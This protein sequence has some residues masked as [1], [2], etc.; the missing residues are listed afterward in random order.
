MFLFDLAEFSVTSAKENLFAA[1]SD[2][3][4]KITSGIGSLAW[5]ATQK[6]GDFMAGVPDFI[7]NSQDPSQPNADYW[8][9]TI[10]TAASEG[11]KIA[12]N[13]NHQ[14]T[15]FLT[16]KAVSESTEG[17]CSNS[18]TAAE[19][20][21]P[22]GFVWLTGK[23]TLNQ[24]ID[25]IWKTKILLIGPRNSTTVSTKFIKGSTDESSY[26]D[27]SSAGSSEDFTIQANKTY[28]VIQTRKTKFT[29]KKL[30]IDIALDS[31]RAGGVGLLAA[32]T[33][34]GIHRKLENEGVSQ[35]FQMIGATVMAGTLI[36]PHIC[37]WVQ[38]LIQAKPQGMIY[39]AKT[40]SVRPQLSQFQRK[41][42]LNH[43][44]QA[45]PAA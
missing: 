45:A 23:Y 2:A 28:A 42:L 16:N 35:E 24:T 9:K 41:D 4:Y 14:A 26:T 39:H 21:A 33:A 30:L 3:A 44:N 10:T 27:R 40:E 20:I 31:I 36:I 12:K 5:S 32:G 6:V 18:F 43:Q 34:Y 25:A 11:L 15:D 29:T 7:L 22:A 19:L 13:L 38:N 17:T 1:S 8:Y 37:R